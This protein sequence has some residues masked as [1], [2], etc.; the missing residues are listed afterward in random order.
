M[1]IYD[2]DGENRLILTVRSNL[3]I[4]GPAVRQVASLE[5]WRMV[6]W[7]R[8]PILGDCDRRVK[9][10]SSSGLFDSVYDDYPLDGGVFMQPDIED[11]PSPNL[12]PFPA[13]T[14]QQFLSPFLGTTPQ[15]II[16]QIPSSEEIN[17]KNQQ[18][19][20]I[21]G[22]QKE[23][24]P[25]AKASS[26]STVSPAHVAQALPTFVATLINAGTSTES[27]IQWSRIHRRK[28][29]RRRIPFYRRI[30]RRERLMNAQWR[31][32]N[33]GAL[34]QPVEFSTRNMLA[35]LVSQETLV[36]LRNNIPLENTENK[37]GNSK[38]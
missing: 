7:E 32:A 20:E 21:A 14:Q 5:N 12:Q 30:R 36:L 9:T 27:I 6:L 24:P 16:S 8:I 17:R 22:S 13:T 31:N 3:N 34:E 1:L 25:A 37:D 19:E 11:P 23:D 29:G 28:F 33:P 26:S 18:T 10:T 2:Q 15:P 38:R 35:D 4:V